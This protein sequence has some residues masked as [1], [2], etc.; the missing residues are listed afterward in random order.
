MVFLATPNT[1]FSAFT[2]ILASTSG[3]GY[4]GSQG[5]LVMEDEKA[6]AYI[7]YSFFVFF[8]DV[9]IFEIFLEFLW[10]PVNN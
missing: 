7:V 9:F 1:Q 2:H 10:Q 4:D 5:R 3:D 8:I 6:A